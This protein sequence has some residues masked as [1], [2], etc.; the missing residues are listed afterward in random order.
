MT[1]PSHQSSVF[2]NR[3]LISRQITPIFFLV[4][5]SKMFLYISMSWPC[6]IVYLHWLRSV[7]WH[8]GVDSHRGLPGLYSAGASQIW[9]LNIFRC[10]HQEGQCQQASRGDP[11][12]LLSPS[13]RD[14]DPQYKRDKDHWRGSTKVIKGLELLSYKETVGSGPV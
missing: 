6:F 9:A 12:S 11:A 8:Q 7:P 13:E 2:Y 3:N 1:L 4:K 10:L 5:V 14:R